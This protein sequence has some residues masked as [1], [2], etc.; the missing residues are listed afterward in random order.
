MASRPATEAMLTMAPDFCSRIAGITAA[1]ERNEAAAAQRA[2]TVETRRFRAAE[3]H[4]QTLSS[5][6]RARRTSALL[7]N[8]D[9]LRDFTLQQWQQLGKRSLF[10]VMATESEHYNLR[11]SYVNA[12]HDQQQLNANLLSLGRGV[13]EWLR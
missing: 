4:E 11:V 3:V 12:L 10:D 8:T 1:Y 13:L 5:F 2:E 6:D 7:K 9:Q